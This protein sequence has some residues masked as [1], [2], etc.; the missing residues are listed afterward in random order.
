[1]KAKPLISEMLSIV[2]ILRSLRD[3]RRLWFVTQCY[4]S[5]EVRAFF[6]FFQSQMLGHLF[7]ALFGLLVAG[8]CSLTTEFTSKQ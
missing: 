3:R 4:P 8:K 2:R 1:M 5:S 6:Q 7:A